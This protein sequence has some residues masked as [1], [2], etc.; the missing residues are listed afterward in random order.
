MGRVAGTHSFSKDGEFALSKL[1]ELLLIHR[2]PEPELHPYLYWHPDS[3]HIL[4]RI[5]GTREEQ[6]PN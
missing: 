2:E 6:K 5:L 1:V 3:G 4:H